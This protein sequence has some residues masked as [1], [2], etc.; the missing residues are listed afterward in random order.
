MLFIR[1]SGAFLTL[2]TQ[3][4]WAITN[5]TIYNGGG[6]TAGVFA[7]NGLA[8]PTATDPRAVIIRILETVLSFMSLIS[9]G[10]V[11]IA[12]IYL[13]VG[14][15]SDDSREKAKKIIFYTLIGLTI[16]LLSRVIVSLVT[17]I[18]ANDI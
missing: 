18:L 2:M 6:P 1:I 14:M 16:I 9:V 4:A 7:T 3:K 10:A 15:G 13:I 12:G 11:I 5:N 8:V 17:V